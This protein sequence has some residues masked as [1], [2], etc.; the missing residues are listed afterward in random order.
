M[1]VD[2][3]DVPAEL[4]EVITNYEEGPHWKM[5]DFKVQSIEKG[6]VSLLLPAR[7][8]FNNIKGT[9]H[10]GILAALLDTTMGM[11]ARTLLTGTPVT[12]QINI[13]YLKPAINEPLYSKSRVIEIGKST[14]FIEG[15]I[16]NERKERIAFSTGT[17]KVS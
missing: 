10:G 8:E 11:T 1:E 15:E 5:M 9:I 2:K 17:F 12:I 3:S 13:Q 7:E 14:C 16:Y 4:A 6:S